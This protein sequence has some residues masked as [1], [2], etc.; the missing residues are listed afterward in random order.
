MKAKG[1]IKLDETGLRIILDKDFNKYYQ[2]LIHRYY[3][4][5]VKTTVPAHGAH[6]S[7]VTKNLHGDKFNLELLKKYDSLEV[8]FDYDPYIQ[9]GGRGFTN[10]WLKVEFPLGHEIK[11]ECDIIEDN[12]LGFHITVAN[13]KNEDN[14]GQW[15]K[16]NRAIK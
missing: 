15:K 16:L 12:F 7:I 4:Y 13:T 2:W 5:V 11:K 10:Y 14:Y 3:N 1:I 9:T 6:I 8:E